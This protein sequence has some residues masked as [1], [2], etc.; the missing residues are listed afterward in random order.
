[1]DEWTIVFNY[2][3]AIDQADDLDD[4]A[5]EVHKLADQT[6]ADSISTI[7]KNWDGDN[8]VKFISKG[9]RLREKISDSGDDIS[10]IA[11]AVRQMAKAIY[12]SEMEAL[13]IAREREAMD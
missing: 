2:N 3:Q 9:N 8:S 4:I 13:R 11:D 1:M 6:L 7:D 12:D 5:R 10:R